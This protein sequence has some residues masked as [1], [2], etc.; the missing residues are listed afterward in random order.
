MLHAGFDDPPH[1]AREARD[2]E[3]ALFHYRRVRDEIRQF[4]TTLPDLL[5]RKGGA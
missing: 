1:L 3:E 4:V 2:E 5:E